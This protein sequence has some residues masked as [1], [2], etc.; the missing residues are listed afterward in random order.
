MRHREPA[1]GL[2][3]HALR[4]LCTTCDP[5]VPVLPVTRMVIVQLHVCKSKS[6]VAA[7]ENLV[8]ENYNVC[9]V[10]IDDILAVAWWHAIV[11]I[12]ASQQPF[13]QKNRASFRLIEMQCRPDFSLLV[14]I[15]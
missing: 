10:P 1:R 5:M 4:G 9:R 13:L 15:Y 6:P 3:R 11:M 12:F 8:T 2:V 14:A 7:M